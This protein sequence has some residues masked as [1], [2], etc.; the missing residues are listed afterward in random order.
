[1]QSCVALHIH[2]ISTAQD[3]ILTLKKINDI[4]HSTIPDQI[5]HFIANQYLL[6]MIGSEM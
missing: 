1:M 6:W 4:N 5:L 2:D 3:Y